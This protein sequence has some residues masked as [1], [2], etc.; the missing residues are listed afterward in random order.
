MMLAIEDA[1]DDFV[2]ANNWYLTHKELVDGCNLALS[3][4]TDEGYQVGDIVQVFPNGIDRCEEADD[5]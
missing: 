3:I 5:E 4:E 2:G 1:D